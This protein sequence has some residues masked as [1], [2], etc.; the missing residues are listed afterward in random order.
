MPPASQCHGGEEVGR[1]Q[2]P[3]LLPWSQFPCSVGSGSISS[4]F[5]SY[6]VLLPWMMLFGDTATPL[7]YCC[8]CGG[9]QVLSL[10]GLSPAHENCTG[11]FFGAA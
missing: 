2:L 3:S 10:Q 11:Y 5:T 7:G 9:W 6:V 1:R 4:Q 8:L